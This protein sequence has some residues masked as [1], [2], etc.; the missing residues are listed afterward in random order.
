MLLEKVGIL[1]GFY[2]FFWLLKFKVGD[3]RSLED[4]SFWS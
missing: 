2:F 1:V 4:F 3:G